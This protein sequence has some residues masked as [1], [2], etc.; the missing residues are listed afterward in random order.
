[1][2]ALK[3]HFCFMEGWLASAGKLKG[4]LYRS[5]DPD[6]ERRYPLD[7]R[8]CLTL[9]NGRVNGLAVILANESNWQLMQSGEV[10]NFPEHA[11]FRTA[12]PDAANRDCF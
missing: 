8:C 6:P 3:F 11:C 2:L 4:S 9:I 10:E 12:V 7:Q 1:M 5:A